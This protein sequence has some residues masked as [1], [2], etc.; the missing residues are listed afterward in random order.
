MNCQRLSA[1][2]LEVE[3]PGAV[4]GVAHMSKAIGFDQVAVLHV[5][6][7]TERCQLGVEAQARNGPAARLELRMHDDARLGLPVCGLTS[8]GRGQV[9]ELLAELLAGL[10]AKGLEVYDGS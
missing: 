2:T 5:D 10:A 9:C 8:A 6:H 4:A 3:H 1:P 7:Q